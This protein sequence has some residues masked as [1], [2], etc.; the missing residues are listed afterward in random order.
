MQKIRQTIMDIKTIISDI[1]SIENG[2]QHIL[3]AAEQIAK[4]YTEDE[5]Y[6]LALELFEHDAYQT[7]MLSVC[8]LGYLAIHNGTALNFLKETVS[9]D[10]NWRVQEMLAK[11]FDYI[12]KIR[13][14]ENSLP[15]ITE[16]INDNN[17]NVVRAVTEGLRIWTSRPYF[18]EHPTTAIALLSQH[19]SNPSEYVRKSVGNALRDI[20]KRYPQLVL[21]EFA[22]W[23]LTDKKL[24]QTYQLAIKALNK[25]L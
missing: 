1:N 6:P 15:L 9:H 21:D 16:W 20:S 25:N 19:K 8:L 10:G 22:N 18:K 7:R 2:F 5:Y 13:G 11:S 12:C 17:P 24:R 4:T 23:D 3:N 14:Y